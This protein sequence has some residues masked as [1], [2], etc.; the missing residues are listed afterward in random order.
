MRAVSQQMKAMKRF[1]VPCLLMSAIAL[2]GGGVYRTTKHGDPLNGVQRLPSELRGE[3]AQ[4][5]DEHASR[6]GVATGGPYPYLLFAPDDNLLC[7]SCHAPTGTLSI[8]QGD[9]S[10]NPSSHATSGGAVWPGPVPPSRPN[11]DAGKRVNCHDPHGQSDAG[12]VIPAMTFQR[13]ESLCYPCHD[14]SPAT[15][16]RGQFQ[17]IS[18]H[19]ITTAGKHD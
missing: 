10:W 14:G 6:G 4:C 17:K 9:A 11:S 5:H 15:D 16:I 3:C 7:L 8:W 13:E 2:A 12:G 1:L 18:K 19:P